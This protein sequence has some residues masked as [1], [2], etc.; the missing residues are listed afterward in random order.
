M[1]RRFAPD[2]LGERGY[3][4]SPLRVYKMNR[5]KSALSAKSR[6]CAST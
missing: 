6:T 4:A 3:K 1:T 5:L 2:A